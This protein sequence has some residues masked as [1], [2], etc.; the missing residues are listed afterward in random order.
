MFAE[1]LLNAEFVA[2]G[3]GLVDSTPQAGQRGVLPVGTK[4][5]FRLASGA[6]EQNPMHVEPK[7]VHARDEE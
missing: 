2:A 6:I 3:S 4:R 5:L 1:D 7:V